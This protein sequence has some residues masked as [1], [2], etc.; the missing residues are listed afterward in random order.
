MCRHELT[1]Q[2]PNVHSSPDKA[3]KDTFCHTIVSHTLKKYFTRPYDTTRS[4][5]TESRSR[6]NG[7]SEGAAQKSAL[8]RDQRLLAA[9]ARIDPAATGLRCSARSIGSGDERGG[10]QPLD[11]TDQAATARNGVP[12]LLMSVESLAGALRTV[13]S[14]QQRSALSH[15]D[16]SH[17]LKPLNTIKQ[18]DL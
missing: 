1:M 13:P 5:L 9:T 6:R 12:Q 8:H 16:L 17:T 7:R 15:H 18:H 10:S 2:P 11:R 4:N 14:E 3:A